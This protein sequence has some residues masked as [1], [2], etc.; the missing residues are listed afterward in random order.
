MPRAQERVQ[1]EIALTRYGPVKTD[2]PIDYDDI[3][4]IKPNKGKDDEDESADPYK[5]PEVRK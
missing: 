5:D 4:T 3:M 1:Q 2:D